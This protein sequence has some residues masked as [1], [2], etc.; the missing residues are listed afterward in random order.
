[1]RLLTDTHFWFSEGL[2]A[3]F[4][5]AK[6]S[7][8]ANQRSASKDSTNDEPPETRNLPDEIIRT[9]TELSCWPAESPHTEVWSLTHVLFESRG[10]PQP[11]N[12]QFD[13]LVARH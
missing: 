1:M 5:D 8:A 4:D 10:P 6:F 13:H 9:V 11:L 3:H 12:I 2:S 7:A